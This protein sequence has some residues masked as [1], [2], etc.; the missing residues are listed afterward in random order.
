MDKSL[1]LHQE[2][3]PRL[4]QHVSYS[5]RIINLHKKTRQ[6]NISKRWCLSFQVGFYVADLFWFY[7]YY[8]LNLNFSCLFD[9]EVME[10]F[11]L[12]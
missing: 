6:I 5:L 1:S 4:Q 9:F 11:F 3:K 8:Q 7:F 2:S 10:L 12:I